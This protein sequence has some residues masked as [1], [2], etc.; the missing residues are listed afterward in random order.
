MNTQYTEERQPLL[1][2]KVY[3]G[4]CLLYSRLQMKR[5]GWVP[6][7]TCGRGARE[8]RGPGSCNTTLTAARAV[9]P[10]EKPF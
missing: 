6:R 10:S 7:S 2:G 4:E 9:G 3:C 1:S 5:R 8:A